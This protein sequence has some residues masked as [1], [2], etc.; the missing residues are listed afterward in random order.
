MIIAEYLS[1][2]VV[3][4]GSFFAG[5]AVV[6]IPILEVYFTNGQLKKSHVYK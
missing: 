5:A 6:D 3:L 4:I 2:P 1:Q